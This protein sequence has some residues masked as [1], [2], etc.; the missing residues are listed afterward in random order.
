VLLFCLFLS[1]SSVAGFDY[2]AS[3]VSLVRFCVLDQHAWVSAFSL[4][5]IDGKGL[6]VVASRDMKAGEVLVEMPVSLHVTGQVAASVVGRFRSLDDQIAIAVLFA[7][8]R[9]GKLQVE[10]HPSFWSRFWPWAPAAIPFLSDYVALMPHHVANAAHWNDDDLLAARTL[11]PELKPVHNLSWVWNELHASAVNLTK[12]FVCLCFF[13]GRPCVFISFCRKNSCGATLCCCLEASRTCL[14]RQF[15]FLLLTC[16]IMTSVLM[17]SCLW[18]VGAS[19]QLR[20]KFKK[21]GNV[22]F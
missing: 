6:A 10:K 22:L 5:Q 3:L 4:Q 17:R 13:G 19:C 16:S 7:S 20:E 14:A 8:V 15:C 1:S 18:I 9:F 21:K 12:A 11:W 2:N